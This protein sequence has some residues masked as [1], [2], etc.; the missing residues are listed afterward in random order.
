MPKTIKQIL[1]DGLAKLRENIIA[2]HEAAGQVA[3]G[4]TKASIAISVDDSHGVMTGRRA[5]GTLETGRKAGRV[6]K[7]FHAI[8]R[9]W[10]IDKGISVDAIPYARKGGG[11]Y[12]PEERGL[13]RMAHFIAKKIAAEGTVLHREGGRTDIYSNEIPQTVQSIEEQV[14]AMFTVKIE[15]ININSKKQ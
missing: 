13:R 3:S 2:N 11:K 15:T 7:N 6:P 14:G 9:Q 10:I 4:R 5:F 12:T 1:S 8:I